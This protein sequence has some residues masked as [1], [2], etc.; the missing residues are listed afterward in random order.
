MNED[1]STV[2]ALKGTK[3]IK[4]KSKGSR[5]MASDFICEQSGYLALTDKSTSKPDKVIPPSRNMP[6]CGWSMGKPRKDTGL[7][8]SS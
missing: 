1:Q 6:G 2:W 7:W 4:S 8:I 3:V 5:I